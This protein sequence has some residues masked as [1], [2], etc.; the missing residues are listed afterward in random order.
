MSLMLCF[1][2]TFSDVNYVQKYY[3]RGYLGSFTI[4]V[5]LLSRIRIRYSEGAVDA[6]EMSL[7]VYYILI[8]H[9]IIEAFFRYI[10]YSREKRLFWFFL[11]RQ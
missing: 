10:R 9:K 4:A 6:M 5:Y 11:T 8:L 7:R 3:T 1:R 2:I